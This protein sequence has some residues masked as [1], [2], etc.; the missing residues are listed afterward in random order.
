MGRLAAKPPG[1]PIPAPLLIGGSTG[2][3]S[4]SAVNK[5]EHLEC[6]F[7]CQF[8]E[9]FSNFSP[10]HSDAFVSLLPGNK[11]KGRAQSGSEQCSGTSLAEPLPD[12]VEARLFL[13]SGPSDCLAVAQSWEVCSLYW[14]RSEQAPDHGNVVALDHRPCS[15]DSVGSL[16]ISVCYVPT[17]FPFNPSLAC[18]HH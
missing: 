6:L 5:G 11:Q 12:S 3:S 17:K 10:C 18:P 8:P 7:A 2:P 13:L 16:M 4:G 1:T 15:S 14:V 9:C